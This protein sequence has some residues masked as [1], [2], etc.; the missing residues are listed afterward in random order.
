MT[1]PQ[2]FCNATCLFCNGGCTDVLPEAV[3]YQQEQ[4]GA[5]FTSCA[6]WVQQGRCANWLAE[7]D[8]VG[9][10]RFFCRLSCALCIP[11]TP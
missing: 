9:T 2:P 5:P 10:A 11:E 6:E 4:T 8:S 1:T 3:D 7:R